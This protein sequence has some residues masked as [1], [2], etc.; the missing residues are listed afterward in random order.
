[1]LGRWQYRAAFVIQFR[2]ETEI[3]R[4]RFLGVVIWPSL[5][6]RNVTADLRQFYDF[7]ASLELSFW[8]DER[9]I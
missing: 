2:P 5:H 4:G 1:V 3:E 8:L 7:S 9:K 6:Y